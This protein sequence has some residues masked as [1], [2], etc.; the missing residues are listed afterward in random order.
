MFKFSLPLKSS[1]VF[2]LIAA[3]CTSSGPN[4]RVSPSSSNGAR[5]TGEA[6]FVSLFDG[7]SL[8]G[9]EMHNKRGDGYGAK[10]GILYC[11]EGGGGALLTKKQ[12]DDFILRFEFLLP[13]NGNNGL[14][15]RAPR[16]GKSLAY[17]A[18]ELQIIDNNGP[19]NA[20]RIRSTQ[21]HGSI[22]DVIPAKRGALRP[23][24]EW[25]EQEVRVVGR[26]VKVILNGK[27]ILDADLNAITSPAV[28]Q[29]HPGLFRE[30]G[31]VGFLGHN[32][33]VQFRNIRI[34]EIPVAKVKNRA[35]AGFKQ[36][37]NGRNLENWHGVVNPQSQLILPGERV[38]DVNQ[39]IADVEMNS[40]WTVGQGNLTQDGK[41]G[42]ILAESEMGNGEIKIDYKLSRGAS[43]GVVVRGATQVVVQDRDAQGNDLRHG[44]GGLHDGRFLYQAP[45]AYGDHF[46]GDWNRLHII[47]AGSRAHVFVNDQLVLKNAR[48]RD[49]DNPG[50]SFIRQGAIGLIGGQGTVQFRSILMRDLGAP[51]PR[52]P[53]D[54]RIN[55]QPKSSPS[56]APS[57]ST[58]PPTPPAPAPN[59]APGQ[60]KLIATP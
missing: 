45:T 5:A 27:T 2:L 35:P 1:F 10:D 60:M 54:I 44:S 15:I 38:A 13:E 12:Y 37:F 4:S 32:D 17:D 6:G 28:L 47:L 23:V 31:H 51:A 16:Q 21:Y 59:S 52:E 30:R 53:I 40:H 49:P 41:G 33:F 57:Q 9:W 34:R 58:A 55:R 56:V 36:L 19:K 22:Y 25:N 20:H 26:T 14:A 43:S 46:T 11:T 50:K 8:K 42:H 24:G 39:R 29:K 18:M 48:L 3:G 7:Y